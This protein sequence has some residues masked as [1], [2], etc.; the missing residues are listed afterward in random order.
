MKK[1]YARVSSIEQNPE[2]Q[3]KALMEEGVEKAH[4]YVEKE[5]AKDT[6]NRPILQKM[7]QELEPGD[8]IVIVDLTR[9]LRSTRDLFDLV[10]TIK[11]KG[12]SLRSI[13]D[14]WLD[15]NDN[16]PYA[17]FLLTIM[18]AVAEL[19]RGLIKQRQKEGIAI[20]KEKGLYNGRPK[21]YGSKHP[22]MVHAIELALARDK[23]INEIC[24]ITK[25]SRA[26]LYRELKKLDQEPIIGE[27]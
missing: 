19:E 16:S 23:T 4:I 12:A 26:A 10:D 3:L 5:S 20:A 11:G 14:K 7:L 9:I 18:T 6:K 17:E 21:K 13:K 22:G 15:T 27:K 25:V 2:R 1:G 24:D 8:E